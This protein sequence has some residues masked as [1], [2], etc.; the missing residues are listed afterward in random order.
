[1]DQVFGMKSKVSTLTNIPPILEWYY[2]GHVFLSYKAQAPNSMVL[3][4]PF[5]FPFFLHNP[6]IYPIII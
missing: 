5:S 2:V 3:Q 6:I 4:F 1:M